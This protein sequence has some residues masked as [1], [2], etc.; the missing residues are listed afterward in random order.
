MIS[1]QDISELIAP[2]DEDAKALV[3]DFA[4]L[5]HERSG[6]MISADATLDGPEFEHWQASVQAHARKVL[7]EH[8]R[9]LESAGLPT[10]GSIPEAKLPKDMA[11]GSTTSV[12]T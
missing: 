3:I 1:A 12:E 11:P 10:D 4:R 7:A 2:L 8:R 9:R 6:L 5:L